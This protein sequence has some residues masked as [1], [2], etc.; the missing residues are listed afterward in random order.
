MKTDL[1]KSSFWGTQGREKLLLGGNQDIYVKKVEFDLREV[2]I[3]S[4]NTYFFQ[5]AKI[6]LH[7]D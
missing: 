1:L 6:T 2:F 5:A 4:F 3:H 7:C